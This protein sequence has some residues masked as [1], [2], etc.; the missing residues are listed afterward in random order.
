[1]FKNSDLDDYIRKMLNVQVEK[2][3]TWGAHFKSEIWSAGLT[4]LPH[5]RRPVR[6]LGTKRAKCIDTENSVGRGDKAATMRFVARE[7]T[8]R[9]P[10]GGVS[11]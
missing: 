9:R 10:T 3:A 8:Q 11:E 5:P 6:Q 2:G 1:M 7:P 4:L